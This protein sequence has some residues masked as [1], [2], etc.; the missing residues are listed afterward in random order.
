VSTDPT[1]TDP[2]PERISVSFK[3]TADEYARYA[4][5]VEQSRRSWTNFYVYVA[6]LFTGIPVALLLRAVAAQRMDEGEAL[7]MVGEY[8]LYAYGIAFVVVWI[9]TSVLTWMARRQHFRTVVDTPEPRTTEFDRSG[10]TIRSDGA[11]LSY[12]WAAVTRCTVKQKLLLIWVAPSTPVMVPLRCFGDDA[13]IAA[14]LAFVRAGI[15]EAQ[16]KPAEA[17]G[18]APK[19]DATPA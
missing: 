16:A 13:A 4:A 8:S 10:V 12:D 2:A 15:T 11:R 18:G 5:I 6:M 14:A 7:D 3:L 1:M 17:A 19:A 9:G